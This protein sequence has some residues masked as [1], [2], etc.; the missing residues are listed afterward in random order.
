MPIARSWLS[1]GGAG[2]IVYL[3]DLRLSSWHSG[4]PPEQAGLVLRNVNSST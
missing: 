2:L 3:P 1:L 4:V